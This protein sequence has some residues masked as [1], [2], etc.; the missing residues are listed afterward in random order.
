M[1]PAGEVSQALLQAAMDLAT[2]QRAPTQ[3]ELAMHAQV[4]FRAA[5]LTVPNLLR[6]GHLVMVRR[7]AVAYCNRPVA[8][9]APPAVAAGAEDQRLHLNNVLA[10]WVAGAAA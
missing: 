3:R 2:E 7:R 1:R 5:R 4:G 9:Y 8:E 10:T 6:A